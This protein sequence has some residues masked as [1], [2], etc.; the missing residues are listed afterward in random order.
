MQLLMYLPE[1]KKKAVRLIRLRTA[2]Q[3]VVNL[4]QIFGRAMSMT[5]QKIQHIQAVPQ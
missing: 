2:F 1:E 4:C 3:M 5:S